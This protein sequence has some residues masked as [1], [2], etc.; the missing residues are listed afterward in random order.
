MQLSQQPQPIPQE[1]LALECSFRVTPDGGEEARALY[2][3]ID[4]SPCG[5]P[6]GRGPPWGRQLR[7]ILQGGVLRNL[8]MSP[9]KT[10]LWQL[11]E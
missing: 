9:Q 5:L 6:P 3:C 1:A 2:A 4:Q 8:T 11:Q 10:T 7:A